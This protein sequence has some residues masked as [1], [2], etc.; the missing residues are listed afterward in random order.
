MLLKYL[1][2]AAMAIGY[3]V[4]SVLLLLAVLL[5]Y[6][7][8]KDRHNKWKLSREEKMEKQEKKK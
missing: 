1:N 8:L 7:S 5:V 3:I 4:L 6:L 2:Y